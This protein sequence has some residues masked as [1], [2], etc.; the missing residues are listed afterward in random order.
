MKKRPKPK[1]I[2]ILLADDH[3]VVTQGLAAIIATSPGLEVVGTACDGAEAI[4]MVDE[5]RPDALILDLRM[6]GMDGFEVV[7]RLIEASV[8]TGILIM[9]TYDTD[10]DIWRCL[11]AGAKGY[12]L[13]DAS[14]PEIVAAIRTVAAGGSVTAPSLTAKIVRRANARE[15]TD[16]ESAVLEHIAAGRTNKEIAMALEIGEGTVKTHVKHL[17]EKLEATTRTEAARNARLRGLVE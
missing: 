8:P 7:K 15:L 16:R 10:E 14:Q 3:P 9:T 17:L 5:L 2:R 6:P 13:K 1:A 4:R 12:L 11:K